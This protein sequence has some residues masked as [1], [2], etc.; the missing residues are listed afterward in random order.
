MKFSYNAVW[1]YT[2]AMLRAHLPL[3]AA[4][5]GAFIFLPDLLVGHFFPAPQEG[6]PD[7]QASMDMIYAY[8][9]ATWYWQAL[10]LL[11]T[12]V[13]ILAILILILDHGRPTVG[14]AILDAAKLLPFYL[15]AALLI[16]LALTLAVI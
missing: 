8:W 7:P 11:V 12:M 1:D 14:S 6:S 4:I 5:A 10:A 13:G 15:L 2:L 3:I 16:G 9:S